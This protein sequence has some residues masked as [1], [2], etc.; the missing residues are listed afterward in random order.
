MGAASDL[1]KRLF[2]LKQG[3]AATTEGTVTELSW[4]DRLATV[5]FGGT[6]QDMPWAGDSPWVGSTVRMLTAGGRPFCVA[7]WG[8]PLG[9]VT[10]VASNIATV[11]GD[12]GVT[13]SYPYVAGAAV[14]A[15]NRVA[16]D[17][18]RKLVLGR[19]STDAAVVIPDV[20]PAPPSGSSRKTQTFNPVNSGN[21]WSSGGR[22]DGQMV[23]V[24]DGRSGYYFYG[25]QIA[26]TIPNSAT[27]ISASIN[28][29]ETRDF[30]PGEPSKLGLHTMAQPVAPPAAITG[31]F[32]DVRGSGPVDIGSFAPY[33]RDGS[34]FGVGFLQG[35][36]YRTFAP[37]SSSGAIT[38]TWSA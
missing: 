16:L 9:E 7:V 30:V 27:L 35:N 21:W 25:R 8:S 28:L 4:S 38:I 13:Y 31:G 12:D 33:L 37:Y 23:E 24:S 15:G 19:L 2:D 11:A 3:K 17:H 20:P 6:T 10:A 14:A 18:A 32:I 29:T 26:D 5:N 1:E 36:G 34:A 22:Y